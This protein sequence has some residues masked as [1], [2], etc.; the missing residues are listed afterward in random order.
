MTNDRLTNRKALVVD[1]D[2]ETLSLTAKALHSFASGFDVVTANDPGQAIAWLETFHP[3]ILL[4]SESCAISEDGML[5]ARV[6][7]DERSQHRKIIVVSDAILG[8]RSKSAGTSSAEV[9]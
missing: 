3:D 9:Y 5:A 8:E 7:A 2:Q 4:V 6:R 1:R